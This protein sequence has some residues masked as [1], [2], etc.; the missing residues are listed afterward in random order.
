[1]EDKDGGLKLVETIENYRIS[2]AR[3]PDKSVWKNIYDFVI[4]EDY[5]VQRFVYN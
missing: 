3:D 1:V 2:L 4:H 5:R